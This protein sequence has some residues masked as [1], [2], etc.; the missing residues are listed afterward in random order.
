MSEESLKHL[1]DDVEDEKRFVC[2]DGS[3]FA[4]LNDLANALKTM[5]NG[6]FI[7]H[8]NFEKN[9]FANWIYDVVG[10]IG[11]SENLRDVR[12]QQ[13]MARKVKNRVAYLKKKLK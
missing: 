12:D 10:D 1:L 2:C 4:N 5:N 3:F 13:E 9:D 8:V 7:D 11:L 6:V